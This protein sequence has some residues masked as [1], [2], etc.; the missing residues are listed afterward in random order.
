MAKHRHLPLTVPLLTYLALLPLLPFQGLSPHDLARLCQ[1]PLCLLAAILLVTD[2]ARFTL[3]TGALIWAGSLV[4]LLLLSC[5]RSDQ[6]ATALQELFLSAGLFVLGLAWMQQSSQAE[7]STVWRIPILAS[8]LYVGLQFTLYVAAL[9]AGFRPNSWVLSFGYDNPRFLNH[10]QT[11]A[12]PFLIEA[13]RSRTLTRPWRLSATLGALG[14]MTMLMATLGRGTML[15]LA[16]SGML[17]VLVFGRTGRAYISRLALIAAAGFLAH[18][19]LF[20]FLPESM[21]LGSATSASLL[22]EAGGD[23]SRLRLW[24]IALADI[25][26]HPWLG[27]GPMHFAHYPN[28]TAA[29]PHNIY[30][31]L[32][33]ELGLPAFLLLLSGAMFGMFCAARKLKVA[34]SGPRSEVAFAAY[35]ACA[36][37]LLDGFVS[38]NFVM[39]MSQVWIVYAAGAL[40]GSLPPFRSVPEHLSSRRPWRLA[41]GVAWVPCL[42]W[43]T[44]TAI[45]QAQK[46]PPR[47]GHYTEAQLN[48]ER[49]RPRFWLDGWF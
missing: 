18:L 4:A 25:E 24:K 7:S 2:R 9:V 29:H 15:A 21:H 49:H 22:A 14:Q 33:A 20:V 41:F 23:H 31:Q 30:L 3:S 19:V 28:P 6:P 40:A 35:V 48:D 1:L 42:L 45:Q 17:A 38:G 47:I 16:L 37:A 10:V 12:L 44:V 46:T 5:A 26:L 8:A 13:G 11:L 43:L 32:A 27:I 36:G 39:P 34:P